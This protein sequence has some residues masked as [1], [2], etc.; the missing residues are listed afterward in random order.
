MQNPIQKFRQSSIIFEKPGILSENLNTLRSPKYPR[1]QYFLLKLCTR[2]LLTN[3]YKTCSG[4]SLCCL[5]LHLFAKI[6]KVGFYTLVFD[7]FINNL[8]SKQNKKIPSNL[9]HLSRKRMQNFIKK[10]LKSMAV[11]AR[12]SFQFFR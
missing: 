6:K 2:F 11:G 7:I 1:F 12:Q 4:F 9:L 8:R 5:D 3:V 10:I